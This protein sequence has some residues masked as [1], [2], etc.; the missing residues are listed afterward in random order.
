MLDLYKKFNDYNIPFLELSTPDMYFALANMIAPAIK[1]LQKNINILSLI[2]DVPGSIQQIAFNEIIFVGDPPNQYIITEQDKIDFLTIIGN[3]VGLPPFSMEVPNGFI[4]DVDRL[5]IDKFGNGGTIQFIGSAQ[6]AR[7]LQARFLKFFG[8][9]S[10]DNIF[11]SVVL[12]SQT[13]PENVTA[14]FSGNTMAF[15]IASTSPETSQL[16]LEYIDQYGYNLWIKPT[17]GT[18]TFT[19]TPL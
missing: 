4:L 8:C 9:A 1:I 2:D 15:T 7:L 13:D 18:I 14:S 12:V 16:F 17:Y 6:Y 5:D 3:I 11:N 19:Y 10:I